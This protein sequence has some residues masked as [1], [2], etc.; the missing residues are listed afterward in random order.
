MTKIVFIM[1]FSALYTN[2]V[3]KKK[4]KKRKGEKKSMFLDELKSF[5]Q[6]H[7]SRW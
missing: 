2:V 6:F 3:L 5:I 1:V 7:N 4:K